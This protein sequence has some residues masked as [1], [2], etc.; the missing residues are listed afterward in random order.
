MINKDLLEIKGYPFIIEMMY[1]KPENMTGVAVYE[2]IGFGNKAY[3]HKQVW[4]MMQK[5]IPLLKGL[6]LQMKI[7]DAYRPPIGHQCLKELIP[8]EGFFAANP[9]KSQHCHATA[10][11]VVL[12][13]ANG[14][15]LKFPTLV[16]A[17]DANMAKKLLKGDAKEFMEHLKKARQDYENED[18]KEEIANRNLLR[19]LMGKVGFEALIHEWWHF[20]LPNGKSEDYPMVDF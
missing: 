10:I 8:M 6:N 18:M 5:L 17:Y 4:G 1:A 19:Q 11:D 2:E 14:V 9:E 20:N 7:C 13:D 15:E 12:C 3:V 16:D